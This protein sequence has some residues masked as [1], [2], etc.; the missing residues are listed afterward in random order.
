MQEKGIC[1]LSI[2]PCRKEPSH[3]S[4]M[5]TQ[6]L[7]GDTYRVL[8]FREEWLFIKLDYDD[9]TCWIDIKQ[10]V[11]M[12]VN[13]K[14][15]RTPLFVQSTEKMIEESFSY[16]KAPY[17]WG[18]KTKSGIDCSGFS[19]EVFKTFGIRLLRDAS[20]QETQGNKVSSFELSQVGDLAFFCDQKASD[21]SKVKKGIFNRQENFYS[22]RLLSIKRFF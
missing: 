17:L 5:V 14:G 15:N 21:S 4:E 2:I 13:E 8:E 7:Q 19:Q 18:G 12:P 1:R 9:Y 11:K 20:Q 3:K 22:H 6:L 10:H 16:L